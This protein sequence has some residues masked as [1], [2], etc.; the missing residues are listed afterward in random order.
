MLFLCDTV[1]LTSS[2]YLKIE[3]KGFVSTYSF[4]VDEEQLDL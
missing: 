3:K 1:T 2:G 4:Q